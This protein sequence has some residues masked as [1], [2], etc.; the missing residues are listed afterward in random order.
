MYGAHA[1]GSEPRGARNERRFPRLP[2]ENNRTDDSNEPL[3][4]SDIRNS[5][6]SLMWRAAGVRREGEQ[7]VEAARD[8]DPW[9]RY[10]LGRQFR[11]PGGWELQNMLI[12]A[13]I[14][15]AAAIERQETR[16]V[17]VRTDFPA[18]DDARW[19]RHLTFRHTS[20]PL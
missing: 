17:H 13:R 15:I 20:P 2:L 19:Q 9:C 18:T 6:K 10:V 4:L 12:V 16:G 7:L 8:I 1:G 14:M 11:E 5:L 3:D